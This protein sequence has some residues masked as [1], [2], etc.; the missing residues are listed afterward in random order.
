MCYN[1]FPSGEGMEEIVSFP[2]NGHGPE[3]PTPKINTP[4]DSVCSQPP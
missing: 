2:A 3:F 4:R 1:F